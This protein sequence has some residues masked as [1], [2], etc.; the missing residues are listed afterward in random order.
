LEKVDVL[1][2]ALVGSV[3]RAPRAISLG[4]GGKPVRKWW[5]TVVCS[6]NAIN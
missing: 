5:E 2:A 4:G 1:Q 6:S 3:R